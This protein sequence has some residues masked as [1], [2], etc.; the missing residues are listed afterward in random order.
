MDDRVKSQSEIQTAI[1]DR[2][3]IDDA[4]LNPLGMTYDMPVAIAPY[5]VYSEFEMLPKQSGPACG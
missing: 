2:E 3:K 1:D 5:L 4:I